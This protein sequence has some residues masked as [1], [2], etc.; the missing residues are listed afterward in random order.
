MDQA[1]HMFNKD[2]HISDYKYISLP[3]HHQ[4]KIHFVDC[5]PSLVPAVI[6][7]GLLLGLKFIPKPYKKTILLTAYSH[8]SIETLPEVLNTIQHQGNFHRDNNMAQKLYKYFTTHPSFQK[9]FQNHYISTTDKN[10]GIAII[11]KNWAIQQCQKQLGDTT[12]YQVFAEFTDQQSFEKILEEQLK[13]LEAALSELHPDY[14]QLLTPNSTIPFF[15][16]VPKVHKKKPYPGRPIAGAFNSITKNLSIALQ[17]ILSHILELIK[18]ANAFL[19]GCVYFPVITNAEECLQTLNRHLRSDKECK[20]HSFDFVSMYPNISLQYVFDAL[21][22]VVE[23]FE[24]DDKIMKVAIPISAEPLV[25]DQTQNQF[26]FPPTDH[27]PVKIFLKHLPQLTDICI[28]QFSFVQCR[29]IPNTIWKQIKGIAMGTNCAPPLANLILQ[30]AEHQFFNSEIYKTTPFPFKNFSR[31]LDD[32]LVP[33]PVRT[34]TEDL[35]PIL[36]QMYAPTGLDLEPSDPSKDD[37]IIFL[38]LSLPQYQETKVHFGMYRKPGN[39]YEYH[40][41]NSYSPL[42]IKKGVVIGEA[43]RIM[44]RNSE[45]ANARLDF[46]K[47]CKILHE[48]RGYP[49][50]FINNCIRQYL[51]TKKVPTPKPFIP[52]KIPVPQKLISKNYDPLWQY[53]INPL[54]TPMKKPEELPKKARVIMTYTDQYTPAQLSKLCPKH[55]FVYRTHPTMGQHLQK[56]HLATFQHPAPTPPLKLDPKNFPPTNSDIL[57][58]GYEQQ[59]EAKAFKIAVMEQRKYFFNHKFPPKQVENNNQ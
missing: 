26:L 38:D 57:I 43:K 5:E 52:S 37:K 9:I 33:S 49:I 40:H 25:W 50:K 19:N 20:L 11:S 14:T 56:Q 18:N 28:R 51:K 36:K 2:P 29:Y 22:E 48:T 42:S 31:F 16:P 12:S 46:Y 45:F 58:R 10:M 59:K 32:L 4:P 53:Y 3:L 21:S 54:P 47:F 1:P 30:R 39:A 44:R 41:F 23:S 13:S 34:K 15:Y 8:E 35:L 55:Q 6:Q 27:I 24:L 7:Q 17:Q